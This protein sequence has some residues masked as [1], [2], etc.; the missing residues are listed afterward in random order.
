MRFSWDGK[1]N[2]EL[3]SEG[4]PT[5][6]EALQAIAEFG[7]LQ[8]GPNPVRK[9]QRIFVVNIKNYPHVIPYEK[10]GD[11]LWLITIYPSRKYKNAKEK[12]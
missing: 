12:K 8:E 5:F 1:K 6:K 11:V 2:I 7:I 10:R 9:D 4:R 3:E